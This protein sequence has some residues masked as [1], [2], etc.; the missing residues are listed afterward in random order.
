MRAK[1][2]LEVYAFLFA[3]EKAE[4]AFPTIAWLYISTAYCSYFSWL[5]TVLGW[6]GIDS[7]YSFT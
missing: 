7:C 5:V 3:S 6:E 1:Y 4:E 2:G